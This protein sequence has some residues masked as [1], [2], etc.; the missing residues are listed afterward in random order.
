MSLAP[1]Q[2]GVGM[3]VSTYALLMRDEYPPFRLDNG[4]HDSGRQ[5]PAERR[6]PTWPDPE[7][8]PDRHR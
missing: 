7:P 5:A 2:N 1:E 3:S 6:S 4:A 8:K